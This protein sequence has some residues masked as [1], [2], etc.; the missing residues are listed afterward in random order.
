MRISDWS[1]YV[2]SSDLA[3]AI[4]ISLVLI[5]GCRLETREE[6]ARHAAS[7][8]S[9]DIEGMAAEA[10]RALPT[11]IVDKAT[12]FDPHHKGDAVLAVRLTGKVIGRAA[13]RERVCQ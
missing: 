11:A 13:C 10:L 5:A 7:G 2:C 8:Q 6:A 12:P 4:L 9:A 3:A 1:S